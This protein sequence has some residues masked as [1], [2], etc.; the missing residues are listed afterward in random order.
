M[1]FAIPRIIV[2]GTHSG[3]GKTT[4]A[5]GLM[6]ALTA[7]GLSVQPF[8][9]GPDFIDPTHHTK[10]CGRV[11]RNLDPFMMGNDGL[12]DTFCRACTGADIAVIEGVMGLFDGIDGTEC[13]STAHVAKILSAPV[14]LVADARGMSRSIHALFRGYSAFDPS[15]HIA[16]AVINRIG[17]PRHRTLIESSGKIPALGWIPRRDDLSVPSRHLGLAMAHETSSMD[18]CVDLIR[19]CCDIDAIIAIARKAKPLESLQSENNELIARPRIGIAWD[20]SFCFYYQDNLDRLRAFGAELV[21]FSPMSERL[22]E[23]DGLYLGG[24]YPELYA[25]ELSSSLCRSDISKAADAGMPVF[26][27]CGGLLYLSDTISVNGTYRFCGIL[28][29]NAEMTSKVQALGYVQG[30]TKAS[31]AYLPAGLPVR[32]HEFHYSRI[33]PDP[34]AEYAFSLKRGRGIENGKDGMYTQRVIGTYTHSYFSNE[35]S[36]HFVLSCSDDKIT[37]ADTVQG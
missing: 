14:I 17:S 13:A 10:I 30:T 7:K 22:P 9:V 8:K 37:T 31:N 11:S 34:D 18:R 24:G 19:E 35:F 29:A 15:V 21:F 6:A 32:G 28:P 4:I 33:I 3:C 23:I 20:P 26:G 1:S 25:K 5:G 2:G 12:R 27:E 36:R 16:G